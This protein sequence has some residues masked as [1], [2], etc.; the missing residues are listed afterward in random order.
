MNSKRT[1]VKELKMSNVLL[2]VVLSAV[3]ICFSSFVISVN[4]K[5]SNGEYAYSNGDKSLF[6]RTRFDLKK[7]IVLRNPSNC[8]VVLS[9]SIS[10]DAMN[11]DSSKFEFVV[12][13]DSITIIQR[14]SSPEKSFLYLP[15]GSQLVVD[16]GDVTVRGSLDYLKQASYDIVLYNSELKVSAGQTHTFFDKLKVRGI[17]QSELDVLTFVHIN[18][19]EI[20]AINDV[21]LAQG[22]QIG[23]LSTVYQDNHEMIKQGD[24]VLISATP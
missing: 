13:T 9:D 16:S 23:R 18:D 12:S 1:R 10:F 6:A 14:D 7:T 4:R 5:L 19:M 15:N 3:G 24:S 17:G 21:V 11:E 8:T 2:L 20:I 22:W